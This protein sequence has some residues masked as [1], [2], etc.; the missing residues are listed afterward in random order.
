MNT[1]FICHFFD[2]DLM[3]ETFFEKEDAE[4][5]NNVDCETCGK[6]IAAK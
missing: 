1:I 3:F 4:E 6:A 2:H 5:Q